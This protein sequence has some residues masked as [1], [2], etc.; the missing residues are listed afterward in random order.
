MA[1]PGTRQGL[2]PYQAF[3]GQSHQLS[4]EFV[5]KTLDAYLHF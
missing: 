4:L 3:H 2:N 1:V 5:P